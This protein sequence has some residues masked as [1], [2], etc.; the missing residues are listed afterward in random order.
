MEEKKKPRMAEASWLIGCILCSLGVATCAKSG[1]G[2]SMVVAPAYVMYR[3][4]SLTVSWFTFG[5]AE[6]CLQGV[7]LVG[8][9]IY[10]KK[11][12]WKFLLSFVTAFVYGLMI[13]G[14]YLLIG[15]D[16]VTGIASQIACMLIGLVITSLSVAFFLRTYFA[17]EA[18]EMVVKEVTEHIGAD[19][20]KVKWIYDISS[21]TVAIIVMLLVFHRFDLT[22][23]GV[24]TILATIINAPIIGFFGRILDKYFD[25][26]PCS[27]KLYEIFEK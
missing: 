11:F 6:Y 8:L 25:F 17:Q 16:Q 14:W 18:Y 19:M 21:L 24:C 7:L 12:K 4:I 2:V 13:D 23:V 3:K 10:L 1:L 9:G 26:T 27:E 15:K 5:M 22:M 20:N